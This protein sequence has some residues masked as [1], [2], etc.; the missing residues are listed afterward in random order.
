MQGILVESLVPEVLTRHGASKPTPHN[1]W[2][3]ALEPVS[4]DYWAHAL[5]PV[6]PSA[7][8]LALQQETPAREVHTQQPRVAPSLQL[9]KAHV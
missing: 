6:K 1:Y 4:H 7:Y 8:S 3:S 5:R 2:A 9:E